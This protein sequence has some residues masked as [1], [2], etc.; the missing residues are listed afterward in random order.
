MVCPS[1]AADTARTR[2]SLLA[3]RAALVLKSGSSASR[4]SRASHKRAKMPS[5]PAAIM[6]SPSE[7]GK[8]W[9]GAIMAMPVP[10][11]R[12]ISPVAR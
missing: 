8:A 9:Y 10:C 3:T 2:R 5:L 6:T 1:V 4:R 7:Q 11:L 12:G